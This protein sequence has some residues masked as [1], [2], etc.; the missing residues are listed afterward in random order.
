MQLRGSRA[1]VAVAIAI[2]IVII[3]IVFGVGVGPAGGVRAWAGETSAAQHLTVFREPSSSNAGVTVI[4]PQT[5]VDTTLGSAVKL[6][7]GYSVDIVSGATPAIFGVDAVSSATKFSDTR[8]QVRGSL[9]YTRPVADVTVGYSYGWEHDYRSHALT[10]ATRSDFA[11]HALT[12]DLSFTHNFDRVCDR[13]NDAAVGNPLERVALV[14]SDHCFEGDPLIATRH[15]NIDSLE[16]S[17]T[18]AVT[19][20]LLVQG[21]GTVQ[22]VDGFQSNPYRRVELGS[23]GRTP[24]E[25]LPSLRQRYAVFGRGAYAVPGIRGS[26]QGMVRV[27]RDTWAVQAY[28]AELDFHEYLTQFLILSALARIHSQVGAVFYRDARGYRLNG[29]VGQYWTG[30]RELSTMQNTLF[31]GKLAYLRVPEAGARP[32]FNELELGAKFEGLFYEL[33]SS[34]AP[35]AD[36]RRAW[37][38]QLAISLRF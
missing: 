16:P 27:Y 28:S 15:L 26:L 22:I 10:V 29:P 32:F 2:V 25:S 21:G 23:A 34:M 1:G 18:W 7:A 8:Q 6:A 30:D 3:V 11:D 38:G 36:R 9:G 19:P 33:A 4:H 5:D 12:L 24:Q 35:N 17:L 14:K 20:R 37:I 31:G 13:N